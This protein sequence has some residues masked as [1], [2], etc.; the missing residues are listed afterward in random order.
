[1]NIEPLTRSSGLGRAGSLTQG[2]PDRQQATGVNV[3]SVC[4]PDSFSIDFCNIRGLRSNLSSVE[5]HLLSSSP[6][7]LLLS[8]TQLSANVSSDLFKINNYNL[9]PR[10]RRKGGVCAYCASNVPVTRLVDLESPSFDVIWLKILLDSKCIFICFLYF[11]PNLNSSQEFFNYLTRCHESLITSN[12]SSEIIFAGDFNAHHVEWLGSSRTSPRGVQAHD[13][14]VLCSLQQL[15]QHPT[16]I[17]DRHD[18]QPNILDLF[19]TSNLS[20]YSY[21]VVPPLDSSDHN[22]IS[23]KRNWAPPP[24]IPP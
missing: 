9:F 18:H 13:F 6:D 10:F 21:K 19:L 15:I 14:A 3:Q 8:E 23:V 7:L 16:R 12:P 17:P 2:P 11:S 1:M 5:H 4:A 24:P 20:Q 22:L